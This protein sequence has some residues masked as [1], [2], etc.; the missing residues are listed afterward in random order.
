MF[1]RVKT[2]NYTQFFSPSGLSHEMEESLAFSG[3]KPASIIAVGSFSL[4]LGACGAPDD[5]AETSVASNASNNAEEQSTNDD[6]TEAAMNSPESDVVDEVETVAVSADGGS[7]YAALT[8]DAATGKRVYVKCIACHTVLEGQNRVGPSLYRIFGREAG[9]VE[10]FNY[11][12]ANA[13]SSITWTEE[14]M[15]AYL[16]NPQE[17]IPGTRMIFAGLPDPQDRADLIAYLKSA[18]E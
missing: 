2:F 13:N 9:S 18:A 6:A 5:G 12:D 1:A 15:F 11:T 3:I 17:Y 4:F 8:G 16:E 7:E 14:I 10:G